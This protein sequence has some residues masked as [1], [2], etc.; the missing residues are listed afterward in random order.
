MKDE[1]R[2]SLKAIVSPVENK[3]TDL[4]EALR[5][6]DAIVS[7]HFGDLHPQMRH[8][9]QN[10]SYEKALLWLDGGEPEKG[11]CQK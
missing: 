2:V 7:N 10:R 1:I 4:V 6:L 3:Q 11:V 8:F 5:T 9:L